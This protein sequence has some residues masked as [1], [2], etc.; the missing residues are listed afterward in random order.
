MRYF[1]FFYLKSL[2]EPLVGAFSQGSQ[3]PGASDL[4]YFSHQVKKLSVTKTE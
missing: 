4:F 1:Q 2:T 3:G